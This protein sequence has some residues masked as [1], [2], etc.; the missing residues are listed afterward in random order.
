MRFTIVAA[1]IAI[2]LIFGGFS[3]VPF[4]DSGL[5]PAPIIQVANGQP[6]TTPVLLWNYTVGHP[7]FSLVLSNGV[8]YVCSNN[9]VYAFNASNGLQFWKFA[10]YQ[11][12]EAPSAVFNDIVYIG[13]WNYVSALNAKTGT[14]LWLFSHTKGAID[15][16]TPIVADNTVY[17]G[18]QADLLQVGYVWVLQQTMQKACL[19]PV[20]PHKCRY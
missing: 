14:Q 9:N 13:G 8:V 7:M 17:F 2:A 19:F 16:T 4:S 20:E 5:F 15:Y 11:P 6:L 12:T 1:T 3:K 18:A 10:T